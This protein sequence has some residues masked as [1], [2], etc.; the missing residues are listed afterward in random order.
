M[1]LFMDEHRKVEGLT[2][3]GEVTAVQE[4]N[5]RYNRPCR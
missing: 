4:T 3:E 5:M 2:A 1:P